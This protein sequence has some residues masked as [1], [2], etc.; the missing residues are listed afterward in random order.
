MQQLKQKLNGNRFLAIFASFYL[1][2][3]FFCSYTR[4]AMQPLG[5]TKTLNNC[6]LHK[7]ELNA[8]FKR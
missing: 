1:F 5:A 8:V 3:F 4:F 7:N 6:Q 2:I